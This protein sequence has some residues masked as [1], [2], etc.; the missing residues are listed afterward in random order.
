MKLTKVF[1]LKPT[2]IQRIILGH[3]TYCV[4][5]LWNVCNYARYNSDKFQFA[6]EGLGTYVTAYDQQKEFKDNF[7]YK[8]LPSQSAQAIIAKLASAWKS[9]FSAKKNGKLENP[10]PPKFKPK[11][12]HST[13]TFKRNNFKIIDDKIRL[14]ISKQSKEYLSEKHTIG[15]KYL[16]I[17]LDKNLSLDGDV[18]IIEVVPLWDGSYKVHLGVEKEVPEKKQT[19]N[20]VSIDLGISNLATISFSYSTD[21][22]IIDGSQ[23]LSVNRYF[24][25]E[26]LK[27]QQ[28]NNLQG[29]KKNTRQIN[30][31]FDKRRSQ[32]KQILHSV[33]NEIISLANIYNVDTIVVGDLTDIREDADYGK[34]TNQKLHK[35][36]F[37]RFISYI[38]YK[39]QLSG[40]GVEKISESYTSQC[41]S[42]HLSVDEID[43]AHAKKSNRKHRGLYI[44]NECGAVLNADLNGSLNILKKYLHSAGKSLR[45]GVVAL[46]SPVRLAWNNHCFN[47]LTKSYVSS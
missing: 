2:L 36:N 31:L 17:D 26:I 4:S 44:C 35:W 16:W 3:L 10:R 19:G 25:K 5:K 20:V 29:R 9:F 14:T 32:I 24:D 13:I 45:R 42:V 7:W 6:A 21:S 37:S 23:L 22:F 12:H 46:A 11:T 39:A 8:N 27:L 1:H 40:I 28:I 33:S 43:K 30:Q 47:R 38:E 18:K 15:S 34:K 41:C